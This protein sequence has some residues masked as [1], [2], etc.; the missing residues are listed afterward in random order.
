MALAISFHSWIENARALLA[1]PWTVPSIAGAVGCALLIAAWGR[2]RWLALDVD[3]RLVLLLAGTVA[4]NV[5]EILAASVA[6]RRPL[7]RPHYMLFSLPALAILAALGLRRFRARSGVGRFAAHALPVGL[8]AFDL[9]IGVGWRLGVATGTVSAPSYTMREAEI[10]ARH[11]WNEGYSFPDVQRHLRGPQGLELMG[12]MSVFAPSAEATPERPMPDLRVLA[13]SEPNRPDGPIPVGGKELDLG[14][15]RHA[16]IL[17]LEGW[18]RL[19]PS[20]VCFE[21]VSAMASEADCADIV[22]DSIA[23]TGRYRDLYER[24][25]PA[26]Q[27]ARWR[28]DGASLPRGR[29]YTWELPIEIT[30]SDQERHVDIVG[31]IGV[32]PWMVARVEGIGHRGKLP[33]RHVVLE[34]SGQR[35]GRLVLAV[36]PSALTIKDYPPDFL[37]TRPEEAA[38]RSSLGRLPPLGRRLCESVGTCPAPAPD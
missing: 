22:S 16:W 2:R 11:F 38:L 21:P 33:G 9:S 1:T 18:V 19:A 23:Y 35:S 37:E 14:R 13:F 15:G 12:A 32:A 28:V 5:A 30:G 24:V 17:P 31:L 3:R 10:L 27:A 7:L 4:I 36:A 29:S 25:F 26:L 6:A 20:R 8:L 34:R